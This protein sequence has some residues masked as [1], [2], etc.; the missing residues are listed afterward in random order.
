[1]FTDNAN[2]FNPRMLEYMIAC[3]A[4]QLHSQRRLIVQYNSCLVHQHI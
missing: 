4:Q 2:I 1:M 3:E